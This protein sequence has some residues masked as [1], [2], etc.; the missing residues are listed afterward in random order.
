MGQ[1]LT[2]ITL[3]NADLARRAIM[4]ALQKI[5]ILLGAGAEGDKE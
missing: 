2:R 3:V 4:P 1:W 5:L